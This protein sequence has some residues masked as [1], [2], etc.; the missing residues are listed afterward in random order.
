MQVILNDVSQAHQPIKQLLKDVKNCL[1]AG[2]MQVLENRDYE[3]VMTDKQRAY[4]HGY[5]LTEIARQA[6]IEGVKHPM[7]VWKEHFRKVYLGKKR[8]R[9]ID[10]MTGKKSHYMKRISSEDLGVKGYNKLIE[11]VTAFACTELN[12]NFYEDFD[13]WIAE[14]EVRV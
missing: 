12:V 11:Q 7:V 2:R 6:S 1:D 14:N 8:V 3:D 9:T 13:S 5:V 10:P 4:Y